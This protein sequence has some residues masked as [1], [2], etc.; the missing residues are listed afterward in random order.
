MKTQK[1]KIQIPIKFQTQNSKSKEGV[2]RNCNFGFIWN[3]AF[4]IWNLLF[5]VLLLQSTVSHA[6][7][8]KRIISLAP[9]ITKSLYALGVEDKIVGVTTYCPEQ[10]KRKEKIGTLLKPNA[11][12]ILSLKPDII[13]ATKEGNDEK[14]VKNI[15][16]F[17]VEVVVLDCCTNFS[18]VRKNFL[19]IAK[20]VN[21]EKKA[22]EIINS[23]EKRIVEI[24]KKLEGSEPFRVFC[25]IG[26][27]PLFTVGG[28]SYINDILVSAGCINIFSHL[29]KAYPRVNEEEVL[30]KNPDVILVITMGD[31]TK[32]EKKR[33]KKYK[34]LK[35]VRD[36]RVYIVDESFVTTPTPGDF[37]KA[38]EY[39]SN[40]IY[41]SK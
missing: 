10:A 14:S 20:R 22:K 4:G 13:F 33:W 12:K 6:G 2:F 39:I 25:E 29:R 38:V 9:S 1:S 34:V 5:I 24:Q 28:G 21:R 40:L 15:M 27:R 11:E 32:K 37:A 18:D 41:F 7:E 26:A 8:P 30:L 19:E 36:K 35:A 17:G 31:A 3:L 16:D 23:A